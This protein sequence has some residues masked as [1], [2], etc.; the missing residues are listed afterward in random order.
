[1]TAANWVTAAS[2]VAGI[3]CFGLY[4]WATISLLSTKSAANE[5]AGHAKAVM[6]DNAKSV[7]VTDFTKLLEALGGLTDSLSKGSPTLTS[8]IGAILMFAIAAISSGAITSSP[9]K[10]SRKPPEANG[11]PAPPEPITS[12]NSSAAN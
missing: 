12:R 2:L 1:M 8:L 6:N 10:D 11:S 5:A 9:T 4:C 7:S 3:V